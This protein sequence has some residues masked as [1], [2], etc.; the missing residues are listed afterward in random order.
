MNH[1]QQK[2][3]PCFNSSSS[4]SYTKKRRR[5]C[6]QNHNQQSSILSLSSSITDTSLLNEDRFKKDNDE[7]INTWS[8]TKNDDDMNS[9]ARRTSKLLIMN[10]HCEVDKRINSR[11]KKNQ[12]AT[13]TTTTMTTTHAMFRKHRP[14]NNVQVPSL[15]LP[16]MIYQRETSPFWN[17][18]V[19][20]LNKFKI[21]RIMNTKGEKDNIIQYHEKKRRIMKSNRK[22][23]KNNR[24][25]YY[26]LRSQW[27]PFIQRSLNFNELDTPISDAVLGLDRSGSFLICV[28]DGRR[29]GMTKII[30]CTSSSFSN[31]ISLS[32]GGCNDVC[33]TD[34]QYTHS[35]LS[36]RFYGMFECVYSV[37]A[38]LQY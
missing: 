37:Y 10:S 34:Y 36:L 13:K 3:H 15:S 18:S 33:N 38:V 30:L 25:S 29:S 31:G 9:P 19:P 1:Q 27:N 21:H 17:T 22:S 6:F 35:L 16:I 14:K 4:L 2:H 12:H 20:S 5:K 11:M 8:I 26:C 32:G 23:A 28:G 7:S 24:G